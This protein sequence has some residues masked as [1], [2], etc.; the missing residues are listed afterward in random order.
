MRNRQ[1]NKSN[2]TGKSRD[3]SRQ[4]TCSEYDTITGFFDVQA[5]AF[6]IVFSKQ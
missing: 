4:N 2:W 6:C 1:T 3:T 5:H